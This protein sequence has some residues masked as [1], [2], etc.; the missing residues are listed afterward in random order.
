MNICSMKYNANVFQ[1]HIAWNVR[2]QRANIKTVKIYHQSVNLIMSVFKYIFIIKNINII[3]MLCLLI[4]FYTVRF[5]RS[6]M[7]NRGSNK[8]FLE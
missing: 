8:E 7:Q 4:F 6:K 1:K 2:K 5:P 3:R